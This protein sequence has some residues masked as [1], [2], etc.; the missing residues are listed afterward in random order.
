MDLEARLPKYARW[1]YERRFLVDASSVPWLWERD[2]WL[3]RD[4]YLDFGRLRL[5]R[6]EPSD[7][8]RSQ[9]K[10]A[11]KFQPASPFATPIVN[12]YLDEAEYGTLCALPGVDLV[13]RR[14]FD[15][16]AK[17]RYGID[18]FEGALTGLCMCETE[19]PSLDALQA[20]A[21][22]SYARVEVTEDAFFTGGHLCRVTP[23]ELTRRLEALRGR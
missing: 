13:K 2:Y 21:L 7:G 3:I 1:E 16:V 5:R 6:I 18:R 10:L 9:Y 11:K 12:I 17:Q 8:A 19:C 4:R 20:L 15:D 23:E 22:P 14:Y